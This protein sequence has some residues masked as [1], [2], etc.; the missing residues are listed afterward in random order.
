MA[1]EYLDADPLVLVEVQSTQ[2]QQMMKLY[3]HSVDPK[4]GVLV[5]SARLGGAC[6]VGPMRPP[7]RSGDSSS[8]TLPI[9]RSAL[10]LS[11]PALSLA[12]A[13]HLALLGFGIYCYM[14]P[15]P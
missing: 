1:G 6:D 15:A 12:A 11:H 13:I 9:S 14:P 2:R 7:S 8:F 5:M 3:L 4:R 10:A